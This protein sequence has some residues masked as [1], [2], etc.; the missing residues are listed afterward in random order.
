ME[1]KV[2]IPGE[3]ASKDHQ[4]PITHHSLLIHFHPSAEHCSNE[5]GKRDK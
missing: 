1:Q 3:L 2:G 5:M 4:L